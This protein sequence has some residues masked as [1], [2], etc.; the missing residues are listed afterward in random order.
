M[1]MLE[2]SKWT[3]NKP[4]KQVNM[5]ITGS[6]QVTA[7]LQKLLLKQCVTQCTLG[8]SSP[9]PLLS[10]KTWALKTIPCELGHQQP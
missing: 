3:G 7:V 8:L 4:A 2:Q 6:N 5:H 1:A 9:R 10:F